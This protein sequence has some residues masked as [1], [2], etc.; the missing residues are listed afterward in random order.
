MTTGTALAAWCSQDAASESV[1][2]WRYTEA[3]LTPRA[4][5]YERTI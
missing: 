5:V 1:P 3:R 4:L 2:T